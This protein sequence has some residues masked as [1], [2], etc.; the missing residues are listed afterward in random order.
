VALL[1]LAGR[2]PGQGP[3]AAPPPVPVAVATDGDVQQTVYQQP[4]RLPTGDQREYQI[5]LAP[6]GPQQL[7]RL[8]S[9]ERLQERMRQE[10]L[11]RS[12]PERIQ[13]PPEP[14]LSRATFRGRNWPEQKMTVE[15]NYVCYGRLFFEERN[16]ERYGW[17]LGEIA[18]LVS[19]LYF[20]KDAACF[21]Y[22]VATDPCRWHDTN[23]GYCLP[24]D[25]VP[26]LL[27]PIDWSVTGAAAEIGAV[28]TLLAVFP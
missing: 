17:D 20:L 27:Y 9:E 22:H 12:P 2:A 4:A 1:F 11:E 13:F 6:P 14:I 7:F 15:P 5:Q 23:A 3:A 28:V 19:T 21:P 8:E 26:Y 18:P 25:P 10:A 24:G 16:A